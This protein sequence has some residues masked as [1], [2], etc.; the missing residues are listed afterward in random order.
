MSHKYQVQ[1]NAACGVQ[2]AGS[3]HV[4]FD[5][6]VCSHQMHCSGCT[7]MWLCEVVLLPEGW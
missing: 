4:L 7:V 2:L 5:Q 6:A 3:V 1:Q